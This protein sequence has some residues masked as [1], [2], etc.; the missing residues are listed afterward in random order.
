MLHA[1]TFDFWGT[2]Y[3]N[4]DTS[5]E[6]LAILDELLTRHRQPRSREELE[7]AYRRVWDLWR[8][9]W[10]E[11][12]RSLSI[13]EWVDGLLG[14]LNVRLPVE[15]KAELG[16]RLQEIYLDRQKPTPV[17]GAVEALAALSRR[18]RLGLISDTGLSPGRILR[19]VMQRDGILSYFSALTFSDETGMTKP[20]Q[21][22][23][24]RT[25][26]ALGVAPQA[27]AHI[28]DLPETDLLG[29]RAV[30]MK[31][32][33]FLGVNNREDGIPLADAHF[34]TYEE[35]IPLLEKLG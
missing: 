12:R 2:L 3:T 16:K 7:A 8:L 19:Y 22:Q 9:T 1:L 15:A 30:G 6:R 23:F 5:E 32:I 24:L 21:G 25:L 17:A 20:D 28:G 29:A 31:A 14:H 10:M 13:T 35:L 18:Y 34:R 33:L 27:A 4:P 11:E 26:E